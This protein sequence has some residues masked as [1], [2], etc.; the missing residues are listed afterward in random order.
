[1]SNFTWFGVN[2]SGAEF[3]NTNIPGVLGTDYT[4]PNTSAIQILIDDGLNIFRIPILMERI[5]P[6]EMTGTVDADYLSGLTTVVDYITSAGAYAIID[7]QNFGRY[8][9]EIIESTSDF[10]TYWTTLATEFASNSLV[11]FDCNNEFHDE[12]ST[13]LVEQLDQACIDGV[14]AAGATSQYIFVEGN[15]FPICTQYI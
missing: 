3:G 12:P 11:I 1:M 2:E 8:N 9:G 5:I 6:T 7:S 10:Q 15:A 13:S 4:W 14:R